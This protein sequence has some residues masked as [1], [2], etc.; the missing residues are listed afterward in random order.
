MYERT[1]KPENNLEKSSIKEG[2]DFIFE[3]H[4]DLIEIGTKEQ[5]SKYLDTIFPESKFKDILW[6]GSKERIEK[7]DPNRVGDNTGNKVKSI[8]LTTNPKIASGYNPIVHGAIINLK[9]D[10][11]DNATLSEI[12]KLLRID[13]QGKLEEDELNEIETL[14]LDDIEEYTRS[15]DNDTG[16]VFEDYLLQVGVTGEKFKE[17]DNLEYYDFDNIHILGSQSDRE[18]FMEFVQ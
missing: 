7:F 6:H 13:L 9:G 8:F 16:K 12:K 1:P 17:N 15:D 11:Y 10:K 14:T 4:P 5:Y 18:K 3:Q 2:V